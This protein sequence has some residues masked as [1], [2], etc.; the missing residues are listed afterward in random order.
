MHL[1]KKHYDEQI[2]QLKEQ[3]TKHGREIVKTEIIVI[4]TIPS[5]KIGVSVLDCDCDRCFDRAF[6]E[7]TIEP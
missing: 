7:L 1:C 6:Y 5:L 3:L 2:E 4:E